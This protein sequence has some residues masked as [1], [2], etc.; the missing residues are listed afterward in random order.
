MRRIQVKARLKPN[1]GEL[2][3]CTF[4]SARTSTYLILEKKDYYGSPDYY[5]KSYNVDLGII[6]EVAIA[7]SNLETWSKLS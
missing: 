2:W 6:M 3:K 5:Y 4:Y 7:N 1:V